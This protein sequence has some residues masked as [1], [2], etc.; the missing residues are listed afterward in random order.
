MSRNKRKKKT[1]NEEIILMKKQFWGSIFFSTLAFVVSIIVAIDQIQTNKLERDNIK[2]EANLI[3]QA[4]IDQTT[5]TMKLK[6]PNTDFQVMYATIVFPDVLQKGEYTLRNMEDDISLLNIDYNL[7]DILTLI[8]QNKHDE[9]VVINANIP[10]GIH[11]YYVYKGKQYHSYDT[12]SISYEAT[13]ADTYKNI[14]YKSLVYGGGD[15]RSLDNL[16][17]IANILYN[18]EIKKIYSK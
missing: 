5:K 10:I 16:K 15:D 2:F 13:I 9:S 3:Y 11:S 14:A 12:Y 6:Y 18:A 7:I 8:V 17:K 1:V 4:D